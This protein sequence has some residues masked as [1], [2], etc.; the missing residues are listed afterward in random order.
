MNVGSTP[1]NHATSIYTKPAANAYNIKPVRSTLAYSGSVVDV[2]VGQDGKVPNEK[3]NVTNTGLEKP[4]S[5]AEQQQKKQAALNEKIAVGKM[6]K[7]EQ[8]VTAHEQAHKA[9]AGQ[10]AG[11]IS[12]D[13]VTG[14]DGRRYVVSGD[15]PIN[16]P[17]GKTP[18]ETI[19]IMERVKRA[20][21]APADPSAQDIAV[22]A[23]A[24]Q[25]QQA[26]RNEI[27]KESNG[28]YQNNHFTS[29]PLK[30]EITRISDYNPYSQPLEEPDDEVQTLEPEQKERMGVLKTLTKARRSQINQASMDLA[31]QTTI[32][33]EDVNKNMGPNLVSYEK[34]KKLVQQ[35]R[36]YSSHMFMILDV[37][38]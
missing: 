23:Q 8:Q 32:A 15:V 13:Y 19:Q 30:G 10:Y 5:A 20:A 37:V 24:A 31:R 3:K 25:M 1:Y 21:L 16:A 26:A 7:T 18:E 4:V 35:Q 36:N 33:Q 6:E 12:Y 28:D 29:F 22:A 17:Q 2:T 9:A 38:A 11:P 34:Y 27:V 14:P